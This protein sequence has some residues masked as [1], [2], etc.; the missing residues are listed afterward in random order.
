MINF[1]Y[2]FL[3]NRAV[4]FLSTALAASF[5]VIA[6]LGINKIAVKKEFDQQAIEM[7][8]MQIKQTAMF[9]Q[10][11]EMQSKTSTETTAAAGLQFTIDT[12]KKDVGAFAL[13]AASCDS[14]KK[15]FHIKDGA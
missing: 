4:I 11:G 12:L 8:A 9:K 15:R 10:M 1:K 2:F 3:R 13:Q 14:I 6:F 5:C 7:K